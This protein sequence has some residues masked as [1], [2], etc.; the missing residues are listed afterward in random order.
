MQHTRP[1]FIFV[2][3]L[4]ATGRGT[5]DACTCAPSGPPCQAYWQV[6]AV[7]VGRVESI[8]SSPARMM[9]SRTVTFTVIEPLKGMTTKGAVVRTGR[10]GGD[11]GYG[12]KTGATYIVYA[13]TDPQ[14]GALATGICSR[15]RPIDKATADVEYARAV[16]AGTADPGRVYGRATVS[17]DSLE[18]RARYRQPKPMSGVRVTLERG[19]TSYVAVTG[20]DGTLVLEGLPAGKYTATAE[21]PSGYYTRGFPREIELRDAL[22]CAEIEVAA[23]FDGRVSGRI[24]DSHRRPVAG[25]TLELTVRTGLDQQFGPRR[26]RAVTGG[27]GTYEFTQVPPGTFVIGLNTQLGRDGRPSDSRVF[28]PGVHAPASA[29]E[30][31]V[32]GGERVR[33]DDFVLPADVRYAPVSGVVL[34]PG[35]APAEGARVY[36]KGIAQEDYILTEPAVTDARGRFSIAALA[37]RAY[38]VFAERAR[39]GGPGPQRL[40]AS[41]QLTVTSSESAPPIVLRLKRQH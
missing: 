41:D 34:E 1:I 25:L 40:D 15:T 37:A 9:N 7:F 27:D 36:L 6:D 10:G 22:S 32:G 30:I 17:S 21:V 38:V 18:P 4:L 33:A 26:L 2:L 14:S 24:L 16:L 11:C 8:T 29:R 5:A 39:G 20:E 35:G 23:F 28:L 19:G 3:G 12:F 13:Y 31:A